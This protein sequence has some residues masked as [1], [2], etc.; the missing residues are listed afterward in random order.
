MTANAKLELLASIWNH[1][2]SD[3]DLEGGGGNMLLSSYGDAQ[4]HE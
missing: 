4:A 3:T 2:L 1:S